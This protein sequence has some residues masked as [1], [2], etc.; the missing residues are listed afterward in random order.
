VT[1]P[2]TAPLAAPLT[3]KLSEH[4]RGQ[5]WFGDA[6]DVEVESENL[7]GDIAR[8]VART[9]D[10]AR[11][12]LLL[13]ARRLAA[14]ECVDATA[15]A[16]LALVL[17]STAA[18]GQHAS[19]V[20]A[21]GVEQSNTS[22]VYDERL[23]LKL[24]RRLQGRNPEVAMTVGL[25]R[26]GFPH[27][28]PPVAVWQVGDD[29]LALLQPFLADGTDGWALAV[30]TAP[31]PF[32]EAARLGRITAT[33]HEALARAFGISDADPGRWARHILER[34]ALVSHPDVDA[35]AIAERVSTLAAVTGAG[36]SIRIHGDY[37]LGQVMRAGGEWYVLDFEGEPT[38]PVA[39][40]QEP[41][42]PLR[43]VAGML[44]SF[45]YAAAVAQTPGWDEP[46]S[47]AFLD[48][49]LDALEGSPLL[50]RDRECTMAVLDAFMLDK[51]VYELGYE[52]AHRPEWIQIPLAAV[53]RYS[54]L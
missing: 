44:R 2:V 17:L 51:A 13:D 46:A 25:H 30:E 53:R 4:L 36:A 11:Y 35:A 15:D 14:G 29:D 47:A 16:A 38:R 26:A 10:G 48:A 6:G 42:S 40:R 3:A 34:A 20:R 9:S 8:V 45:A 18:P 1:E 5:R 21:M 27:V 50:P 22:L 49:Y 32:T 41:S 12:Q 39:E 33:M 37:H 24:F 23:V 43:D 28:V 54:G 7:I 52:Q 31:R 19:R